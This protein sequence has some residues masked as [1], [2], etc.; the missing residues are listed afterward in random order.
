MKKDIKLNPIQLS[1]KL[2]IGHPMGNK[3]SIFNRISLHK[4]KDYAEK[5]LKSLTELGGIITSSIVDKSIIK[6]KSDTSQVSTL[7]RNQL[8][9]LFPEIKFEIKS[10]NFANGN[11][12]TINWNDGPNHETISNIIDKY[13]LGH[14]DGMTDIYVNSNFNKNIPQVK[15]ITCS[16]KMSSEIYT[17]ISNELKNSNLLDINMNS[18]TIGQL[19][20]SM[21]Q[22]GNYIP[23]TKKKIIP[24][25]DDYFKN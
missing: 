18:E 15:Y 19:I 21:F 22:K 13:R 25:I 4:N 1:A 5:E 11:S 17:Q 20:Y 7:I 9:K 24:D 12:V 6:E 8:K 3:N 2:C 14:F 16:R 10:S 23:E